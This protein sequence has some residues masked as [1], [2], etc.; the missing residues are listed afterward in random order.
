MV[1]SVQIAAPTSNKQED[2]LEDAGIVTDVKDL[3]K[4]SDALSFTLN[5]IAVAADTAD[6]LANPL[7][8]VVSNVVSWI[9][10]HVDPLPDMLQ[11]FTGDPEKVEAAART[12]E[13]I[14]AQWKEAAAELENSVHNGLDGQVCRTLN[15]YR[16]QM[17][18]VVEAFNSMGDACNV[19]SVCLN[20]LS[21]MVTI[22]YD[23]TRE[24]IGDLIGTF[25]QAV[26]EAIFSVGLAL[27]VIAGQI[28]TTVSKWVTR[29]TTKGKQVLNGFQEALKSFKKLDGILDKFGSAMKKLFSHISDATDK[30]KDA[31]KAGKDKFKKVRESFEDGLDKVDDFIDDPEDIL[32]AG[33]KK[34]GEFADRVEDAL[35]AGKDKFKKVRESFED[36]L[37]KVEDFIDDPSEA[38]KAGKRKV[39]EYADKI[40]DGAEHAAHQAGKTAQKGYEIG[41]KKPIEYMSKPSKIGEQLGEDATRFLYRGQSAER[42]EKIDE[43]FARGDRFNLPFEKQRKWLDTMND[44]KDYWDNLHDNIGGKLHVPSQNKDD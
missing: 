42:L 35:D 32:K 26:A 7:K 1:S 18:G 36:G 22:V 6:L 25:T 29:I 13:N 33:K 43:I 41:V 37:D 16:V 23:L 19:V 9:I 14:G 8:S 10:A 17:G 30:A 11:Q 27:P 15:A 24:A 12:W 38:L 44:H 28:A 5:S 20:I 40:V 39:G 2:W 21:G 3:I 34:A 31:W 4:S